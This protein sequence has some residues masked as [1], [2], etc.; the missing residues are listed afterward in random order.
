MFVQRSA[1][2]GLDETLYGG[3]KRK[4][5]LE[6]LPFRLILNLRPVLVTVCPDQFQLETNEQNTQEYSMNRA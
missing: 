5:P 1:I 6:T 3:K 4:L 2:V